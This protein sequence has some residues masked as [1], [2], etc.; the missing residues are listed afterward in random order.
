MILLADGGSTKVHWC[1]IEGSKICTEVYTTGANPFFRTSEC[2][3]SELRVK[4]LPILEN[5]SIQSVH[6]FGAGCAYPQINTVIEKAI[7]DCLDVK[8]IEVGSDLMAAAKGLLGRKAGIACILGTGSNSCYY[9]GIE[10]VETV[11]PLG[12]ILGD[13]GSGAVLGRL[14]VGACL[15]NQLGDKIKKQFFEEYELTP[16]LILN[17]VY[18]QPL[19]N[20]FLAS[21]SP[22]I[23]KN[24][25]HDSVYELV[26]N[27]FSDFF[28]KNVMQ[29]NYEDNQVS[30]VGSVAYYFQTIIL[31]VAEKLDIRIAKIEQSPMPGLIEYYANNKVI[32]NDIC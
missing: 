16:Q 21:L 6:F 2:I 4:L 31:D 23:L 26:Y 7:R 28:K 3:S 30:L 14:F 18:K 29:Y 24:I 10:I 25:E 19:P 5:A 17:R 12:Y 32:E 15:K 1:L 11:S 22:F 9:N 27:S 8:Q 13:E 20:Q